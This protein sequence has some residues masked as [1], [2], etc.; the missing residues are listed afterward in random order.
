M[1]SLNYYRSTIKRILSDY[2]ALAQRT[3]PDPN[4]ETV[5]IFDEARD[6]YLVQTVGWDGNMRV[7]GTSI[8]VRIRDDKIWVEDDWT[9]HQ[10]VAQLLL[11]GIPKTKSSSGSITR[12][13]A[14]KRSSPW[15]DGMVHRRRLIPA[16]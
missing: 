13:C 12:A 15:R 4:C 7:R 10:V 16:W 5:C 11:A 9:E 8:Y 3:G 2:A 1:D 6:H 14:I